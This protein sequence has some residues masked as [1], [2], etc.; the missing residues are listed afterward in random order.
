MHPGTFRMTVDN[1]QTYLLRIIN[2][3][4]NDEMFFMVANH[5]LTVVGIDGAYV[6]PIRTSYIMITPGQTM[7]VLIKADK[8]RGQYYMAARAYA[9]VVFGN[10]TTTGI[11]QYSGNYTFPSK[12][13]LPHLPN[14]T[15]IDSATNFTQRFRALASKDHPVD[16]P[17]SID[18]QFL[19]TI[20]MNAFPCSDNN[21]CG[22][23]NGMRLAASMNNISFVQPSVDVLLAYYWKIR[24]VY[25]SNFPQKPPFLFNFT[26]GKTP[27][28]TMVPERGTK[29][30][31][32][33]YN[34]TVEI[35]FQGTNVV[36]GAENH[37]V[38]LHGYSFYVVA[39]G[40]GNFNNDTDPKNYNLVDP[41]ELNTIGVPKNGWAAIRFR[42]DNPG[43]S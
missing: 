26:A 15:D 14:L 41:P 7:D 10:T 13:L 20:S 21:S 17:R 33:E 1:D 36:N 30:R 35:V 22:G 23:P 40:F 24:H 28:N 16:V 39:T 6:K 43:I 3:I 11:L 4:M 31:I 29:V 2:S 32:L 9:G 18:T 8:P 25:E 37:P 38:H 5:H 34:S 12:L 19:I 42:A 27:D